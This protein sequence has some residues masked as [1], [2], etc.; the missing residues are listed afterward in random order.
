MC[1]CSPPL[2]FLAL[3]ICVMVLFL[4]FAVALVST[5]CCSL[6]VIARV[7]ATYVCIAAWS[8]LC[9]ILV[10]EGVMS[11]YFTFLGVGA[12]VIVAVA[13]AAMLLAKRL[14]R[15]RLPLLA[16]LTSTSGSTPLL[17]PT[18][19]RPASKSEYWDPNGPYIMISAQNPMFLRTPTSLSG[20]VTHNPLSLYRAGMP[21]QA[22]PRRVWDDAPLT[23]RNIPS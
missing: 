19:A 16:P 6:M 12:C 17:T 22:V 18:S 7:R 20:S 13:A 15:S 1:V 2:Q 21:R 23:V 9:N 8:L 4:A 11:H 3:Q 10:H 5:R 14:R